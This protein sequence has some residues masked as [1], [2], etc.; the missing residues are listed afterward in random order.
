MRLLRQA[1]LISSLALPEPVVA[2]VDIFKHQRA[3]KNK[4]ENYS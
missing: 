4:E 3:E 2:M 1:S